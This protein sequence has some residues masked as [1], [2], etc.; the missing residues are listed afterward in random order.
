MQV[1]VQAG[2]QMFHGIGE[3]EEIR[4]GFLTEAEVE[5][6][7]RLSVQALYQAL[8]YVFKTN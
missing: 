8:D 2:Q 3:V 7:W 5:Q 1:H 4:S 6:S